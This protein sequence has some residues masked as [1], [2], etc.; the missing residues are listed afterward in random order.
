MPRR[1]ASG[2]GGGKKK[3]KKRKGAVDWYDRGDVEDSAT[4]KTSSRGKRGRFGTAKFGRNSGGGVVN[5]EGFV[6]S[7]SFAGAKLG[8]FFGMGDAG[9]GYYPDAMQQHLLDEAAA[10]M[11]LGSLKE[12][13]GSMPFSHFGSGNGPATDDE[14][15]ESLKDPSHAYRKLISSL[16]NQAED[17]VASSDENES[18][19]GDF[20]NENQNGVEEEADDD[21]VEDHESGDESEQF[22][23][24]EDD[25]N[26][27]DALDDPFVQR[28][29]APDND[30][31]NLGASSLPNQ[32]SLKKTKLPRVRLPTSETL[33]VVRMHPE[34]IEPLR[35]VRLPAKRS[36]AAMASSLHIKERLANSWL[37]CCGDDRKEKCGFSELQQSMLPH[38]FGYHDIAFTHRTLENASELRD[39]YILHAMNHV[40]KSMDRIHKHNTILHDRV[41]KRRRERE[42]KEAARNLSVDIDAHAP[43]KEGRLLTEADDENRMRDQGFTRPKVLIMVPTKLAAARIVKTMERLLPA[44]G[45]LMNKARFLEEFGNGATSFGKVFTE[46]QYANGDAIPGGRL[47][48]TADLGTKLPKSKKPADWYA[49][50]DGDTEDCFRIGIKLHGRKSLK[51]YADFYSADFILASPLGLRLATGHGVV[52]EEGD[53]DLSGDENEKKSG[54]DTDFLSSIEICVVDQ[55]DM[56]RMQ[57]WQHVV[58]MC[59]LVNLQPKKLRPDMDM[60]RVRQH[61]LDGLSKMYRQT[62]CL[63]AYPDAY[64]RALSSK[65]LFKSSLGSVSIAIKQYDGTA[66]EVEASTT[67]HHFEMVPR[68]I[69]ERQIAGADERFAYFKKHILPSIAGPFAPSH[70]LLFVPS[71]FDYV[72]VRNLLRAVQKEQ[73]PTGELEKMRAKRN[74]KKKRKLYAKEKAEMG[75]SSN[76]IPLFYC[77]CEYT[78]PTAVSRA[79]GEF[80]HGRAKILL[81]TE[82]FHFYFRY[83]LGGIHR[84][85]FYAP[86][87]HAAYYPEIVDMV[88]SDIPAG[89]PFGGSA[90]IV[91][92]GKEDGLQLE[93]ITGTPSARTMLKSI[94]QKAAKRAPQP[95]KFFRLAFK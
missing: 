92:V 19:D 16:Q 93:R 15:D 91:L 49:N 79:R 47:R 71:Y 90:S 63:S 2:K 6:A 66:A 5:V 14:L 18:A 8:F 13:N 42:A 76:R 23:D 12:S 74:T 86:P 36:P 95:K 44:G 83:H 10:N 64:V 27:Q 28:Y 3:K 82:R 88:T 50:F 62:I 32:L 68:T 84:V 51:L 52:G 40:I 70:T 73:D 56:L 29:A 37:S 94:P 24:N 7:D 26:V 48:S 78:D 17:E 22:T 1:S 39:L 4:G 72:R 54:I 34:G 38:M 60:G 55:I 43:R 80:Q 11:P 89:G 21:H 30:D 33:S 65:T 81:T 20:G 58:D 57:N 61:A 35:A 31:G 87:S 69:G 46:E 41:V 45:N 75:A 67:R 77:C 59:G 25:Q 9:L 85:L 53:G